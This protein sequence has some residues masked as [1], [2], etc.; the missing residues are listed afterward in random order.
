MSGDKSQLNGDK[1]E[2]KEDVVMDEEDS[3]KAKS[4]KDKDGD[5]EMTVVVPPSKGKSDGPNIN[6]TADGKQEEAEV[7]PREK[8][9]DGEKTI[10]Q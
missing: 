10:K 1:S 7:D 6:G 5:D 8:A 4:G 2:E 3:K 9:L